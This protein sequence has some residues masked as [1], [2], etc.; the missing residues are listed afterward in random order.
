MMFRMVRTCEHR[1]L[2]VLLALLCGLQLCQGLQIASALEDD[3]EHKTVRQVFL[4]ACEPCTS[5][6][7]ARVHQLISAFASDV[8]GVASTACVNIL[9]IKQR[10]HPLSCPEI[11]CDD[12]ISANSCDE[13]F[14]HGTWPGWDTCILATPEND[15]ARSRR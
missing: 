4:V 5:L 15:H 6:L 12:S 2:A 8:F 3:C 7:Q 9:D 1:F 10:F 11:P 14:A 13:L